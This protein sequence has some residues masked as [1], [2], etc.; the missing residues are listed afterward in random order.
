MEKVR[1]VVGLYL[2][3]PHK[4]VVLCLDE[5][6]QVQALERSQPVLPLRFGQVERQT[7]DYVRHGTLALFA[8]YDAATGKVLAHCHRKHRHQEFLKFL[9]RI[10]A[11]YPEEDAESQLHLILDHYAT[12]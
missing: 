12:C 4:A 11:E 8:P 9:E 6:S 1:D 2:D 5:K 10:D 7:H 3:P